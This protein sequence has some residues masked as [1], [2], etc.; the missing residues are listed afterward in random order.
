M[1]KPAQQKGLSMIELLIALAI[2]SFLILGITQIYIDNKQNY[3]FQQAQ[4]ENQENGRF[5][6]MLLEQQLSKVGYRRRPDIDIEESFGA[7]N[8]A[9]CSFLKGQV[10][11][12]VDATTIC[13]R[14]QP[15]D[16][17]EANCTGNGLSDIEKSTISNAYT[18]PNQPLS[19][20][21]RFSL[22]IDDDKNQ[23]TCTAAIVSGT[24]VSDPV[25]GVLVEGISDIRY[26]FGVDT[27]ANDDQKAD[28]FIPNP[29]PLVNTQ[30]I[31]SV[32]YSALVHSQK[33]VSQGMGSQAF[34]KWYEHEATPPAEPST[35]RLYQISGSTLTLRNLMP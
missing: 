27:D 10:I 21:E 3:L 6:L 17:E 24:L 26:E 4:S 7:I 2:S 32:R 29:S 30:R 11:N 20:I 8:G 13:I 33:N 28:E 18:I 31:L 25:T 9:G 23:L 35:G 1:N 22:V 34:A 5:T 14:Y 16:P 15:R 19:Y 12:S